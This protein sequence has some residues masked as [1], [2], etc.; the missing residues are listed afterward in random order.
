LKKTATIQ[1]RRGDR[2]TATIAVALGAGVALLLVV[3]LVNVMVFQW[4]QGVVRA[5][6]DEGVRAGTRNG[7]DV[8]ACEAR[9]NA[10]INDL[11]A[12]MAD[13]V[14]VSCA[15]DGR[16]I[17]ATATVSWDGWLTSIADHHSTIGAAAALEDR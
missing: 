8:A 2:G 17:T 6:L 15:V 10:V 9:A 11:A 4:G 3:Q 13:G 1:R 16:S 14:T 12:G 5:G 7:G